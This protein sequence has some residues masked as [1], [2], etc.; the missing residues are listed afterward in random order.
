MLKLM[1]SP[2][3]AADGRNGKKAWLVAADM[4]YGHLRA[5][6]PLRDIAEGEVI[7]VGNND[8][9]GVV[10]KKLWS[11]LL[12]IY[13]LMS[14]ARSIPLVGKSLFL[15]VETLLHIP[16]FYPI[17]NLSSSTFQVVLLNSFIKRGLCSGV[18]QE[19]SAKDLPVV[20]SFYA[21][22]I[23][24]DMRGMDRVYCIICDADLNRVWVA[25]EPWESRIHYFAPCGKA[26]QRLQA[27]GVPRERIYLTGFPLPDELLGGKDLSILRQDL[28]QRLHYLDPNNR[29]WPLHSRDVEYFLGSENCVFRKTRQL[30]VTYAVGGAGAQ[31]E[32]GERIAFSLKKKLLAGEVKLN[33][34]AGTKKSVKDFFDRVKER[35]SPETDCVEVV[36]ED[37]TNEYFNRFNGILRTTDILWT[38]PSELSFYTALGMPIVMSPGIG[39]QE[40]FNRKWLLEIQAGIRQEN[41]EYTDQ[42]LYDA[43]ENGRFAEA[44]WSGFLKARKLGTYKI[45]EI[46]E[47]GKILNENSPLLR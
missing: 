16:S 43:L 26:A 34:V 33:L 2:A 24:A 25:K 6:Y 10:E 38:K 8:S 15:F 46:L 44:A 41:P 31:K 30:T 11:Q 9:A 32:I 42:W 20:T 7:L 35:I 3:R 5:A 40:Y 19:I 1:N 13:G 17:R 14:R 21:T 12:S 18:L 36:Y 47:E 29:F 23:A 28:G 22:A 39:S 45:K 4:G 37:T 27:Y